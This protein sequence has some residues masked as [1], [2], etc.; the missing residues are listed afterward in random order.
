MTGQ[1]KEE[2]LTRWG[3]LGLTIEAGTIAFD[4]FLL[5]EREFLRRPAKFEF[6]DVSGCKSS[7]SI[8][9]GSLA[10]TF[11]QVPI[12]YRQDKSEEMEIH[13]SNGKVEKRAG[14]KLSAEISG[15]IFRRDGQVARLTVFC[16]L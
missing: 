12:V 8:P 7:I 14:H 15:H 13:Y 10:F 5:A 16:S 6:L 1:V 4:P 11:C 2:I 9:K 3:E